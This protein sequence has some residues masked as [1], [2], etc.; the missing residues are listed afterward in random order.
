MQKVMGFTEAG[1]TT[2]TISGAAG[3]IVQKVQGSFP[4]CTITVY[5]AGTVTIASIYADDGITVKANPFTSAANGTW[6]FYAANGRYDVRFSGTGISVPFTLGDFSAFDVQS[7]VINLRDAPFYA[8]G[9]N[10]TDDTTAILAAIAAAAATNRPIFIPNGTFLFSSVLSF[11]DNL[12]MY[13]TGAGSVLKCTNA[14]IHGIRIGNYNHFHDFTLQGTGTPVL[15]LLPTYTKGIAIRMTY[16]DEGAGWPT[17]DMTDPTKWN[18][19]GA[20]I[21]NLVIKEWAYTG[22]WAAP[23]MQILNNEFINCTSEGVITSGDY[24]V[25]ENNYI[26]GTQSWGIDINASYCTIRGNRLYNVGNFTLISAWADGNDQGGIVIATA[27]RNLTAG[28]SHNVVSDNIIITAD[29]TAV[30]L[31]DNDGYPAIG[32]LITDN[33][34]EDVVNHLTTNTAGAI[35]VNQGSSTSTVRPTTITG[36]IIS[37]NSIKDVGD[38]TLGHAAGNGVTLAGGADVIVADNYVDGVLGAGVKTVDSWAVMHDIVL[39]GNKIKNHTTYGIYADLVTGLT[40]ADTQISNGDAASKGVYLDEVSSTGCDKV[41]INNVQVIGGSDGF[42]FKRTTGLV[43]SSLLADSTAGDGIHLVEVSN[44][45][46]S[47][48]TSQRNTKNGWLL[49]GA[50]RNSFVAC[51]GNDNGTGYDGWL[52]EDSGAYLS[53]QNTLTSCFGVNSFVG[54]GLQEYGYHETTTITGSQGNNLIACVWGTNIQAAQI[55]A[56]PVTRMFGNM[57]D[58]SLTN[59]IQGPTTLVGEWGDSIT[60]DPTAILNLTNVN[61]PQYGFAIPEMT[62]ATRVA[63]ATDKAWVVYD[64][65]L[66]AFYKYTQGTGWSTF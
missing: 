1:N 38:G 11:P 44:A 37:G 52:L 47:S 27:S 36:T 48:S 43:V 13:G 61:N 9:D 29:G 41:N 6:F 25:I 34:I 3:T 42:T 45:R 57:G 21:E 39:K 12:E 56:K 54:G 15:P 58:S 60:D 28:A 4:G 5:L 23:H 62:T 14:N 49:S 33:T 63:L 65:D 10:L 24:T 30:L 19:Y 16:V 22:I 31:I 32:N 51:G 18:G 8:K 55:S 17:R 53:F 20:T 2:L 7:W 26:S 40:I 46:F 50:E 66:H 35:S 59:R 64:I